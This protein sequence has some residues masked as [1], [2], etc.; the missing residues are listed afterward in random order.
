MFLSLI[1]ILPKSN[2]GMKNTIPAGDPSYQN[3][4]EVTDT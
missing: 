3:S 2:N 4:R 1:Y